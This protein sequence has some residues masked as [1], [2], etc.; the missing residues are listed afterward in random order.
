MGRIMAPPQCLNPNPWKQ[1]IHF[2]TLQIIDVALEIRVAG[3]SGQIW[4]G[5][6][7]LDYLGGPNVSTASL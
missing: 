5:E 2:V 3:S 6:S 1:W 4:E 7:F